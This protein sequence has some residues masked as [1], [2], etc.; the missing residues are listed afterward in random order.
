MGEIADK[1][2]GMARR[3][4]PTAMVVAAAIL[5]GGGTAATLPLAAPSLYRN[6]PAYGFEL[7]QVRKDLDALVADFRA[8]SRDPTGPRDVRDNQDRIL[9]QLDLIRRQLEG[10]A[11]H[12]CPRP[13]KET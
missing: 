10:A 5:G 12:M 11:S 9:R 8:Y 1:V 6:D 7:R 13:P 4:N 3:A 2:N